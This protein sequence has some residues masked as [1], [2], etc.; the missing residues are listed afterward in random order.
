MFADAINSAGE[1]TRPLKTI[2]RIYGSDAIVPSAA[3][4]FFVNGDGWAVTCKHVA[5][6]MQEA[7][8]INE[9]YSSFREELKKGG[10]LRKLE[11]QYGYTKGTC[12]QLK[13]QLVSGVTPIGNIQCLMHPEYDIAAVH[14][15]GYT[16]KMYKGHAV[17][18]RD[19]SKV[20]PGD[21]LCRLG[22]PFPEFRDFGYDAKADDI[23]WAD[24]AETPARFPLEGMFTRNLRDEKGRVFALELSTPG[25]KGQSGGP[26]FDSRGIIYGMQYQ[27]A[28]HYLGFDMKDTPV[29]T[30]EGTVKVSNQPMLHTGNCIRSDIITE[31]LKTNGIKYYIG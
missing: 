20:Q 1:Y 16:K 8:A 6:L 19:F 2:Q 25:L 3:A 21:F 9:R 10:G 7:E 31:F 24:K 28:H 5:T 29:M 22:Y 15:E 12:I 26:L 17:F 4:M 27:T 23:V 18:A 13:N 14:F 30:N 11:K